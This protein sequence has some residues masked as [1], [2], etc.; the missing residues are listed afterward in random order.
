MRRM[1]DTAATLVATHAPARSPDAPERAEPRPS[2]EVGDPARALQL[3]SMLEGGPQAGDQPLRRE[4]RPSDLLIDPIPRAMFR[5]TDIVALQRLAGNR[6]VASVLAPENRRPVPIQRIGAVATSSTAPP[7]DLEAPVEGEL[8]DVAAS[9]TEGA[10]IAPDAAPAAPADP[11]VPPADNPAAAG[12]PGT[13]TPPPAAPPGRHGGTGRGSS[14]PAIAEAASVQRD[15]P[16]GVAKKQGG[17][18]IESFPIEVTDLASAIEQ[19]PALITS[20]SDFR[21]KRVSGTG[22]K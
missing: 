8:L 1:P 13:P 12:S 21:Y 2:E 4:H 19:M 22:R 17:P 18:K 7:P 16:T 3:L 6:A 10:A 20:A 14:A 15:G 5:P 9:G 11:E